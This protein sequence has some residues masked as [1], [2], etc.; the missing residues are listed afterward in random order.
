MGWILEPTV[1][2]VKQDLDICS[3]SLTQSEEEQSG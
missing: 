1:F 2:Y 3:Y